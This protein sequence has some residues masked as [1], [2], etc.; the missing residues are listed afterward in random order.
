MGLGELHPFCEEEVAGVAAER[1]IY[2]LFQ[3]QIPIHVDA[4]QDLR[5]GLREA[6]TKFPRASHFSVETAASDAVMQVRLEELQKQMT[7]VR[8]STF[9]EKG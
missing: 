3:I 6:R 5:S 2:V 7:R 4:T 9:F 1:G 8:A